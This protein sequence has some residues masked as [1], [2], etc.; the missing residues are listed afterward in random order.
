MMAVIPLPSSPSHPC[1]PCPFGRYVA[2]GGADALLALWSLDSM[3]CSSSCSRPDNPV[4][5][6][7]FSHD[8]QHLAYATVY[9]PFI[10]ILDCSTGARSAPCPTCAVQC[11]PTP[12]SCAQQ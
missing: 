7:G 8:S 5:S 2:T 3:V 12:P 10:D 4:R 1:P 9:D 11:A 6:I